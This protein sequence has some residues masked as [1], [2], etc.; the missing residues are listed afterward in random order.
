MDGMQILIIAVATAGNLIII[1]WKFEHDRNEDA[2]LDATILILL[3][4]VFGKTIAGL[5]IA[6]I[7]SVIVSLYLLISPPTK[8]V[9]KI[10]KLINFK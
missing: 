3:A 1:K 5:Q 8:L 7:T 2:L 4:I 9:N 6:T 10:K